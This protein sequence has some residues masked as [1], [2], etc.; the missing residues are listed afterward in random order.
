MSAP[1]PGTP[2]PETHAPRTPVLQR[3]EMEAWKA[4]EFE[5][6]RRLRE[7]GR[8]ERRRLYAEA[9]SAV[10]ALAVQKC[11][12]DS[13]EDRTAG[14]SPSLVEVLCQLVGRDDDVLEVGCG[15]GYT[16]LMLASHVRSMVGTEVSSSSVD[17]SS[18][19]MS[20]EGIANVRIAL[21]S[22]VELTDHFEPG[23]FSACLSIDV[24]E[25]LHPEDA[26][27]HLEQVFRLLRPGGRYIIV[28]PNR[29]NGPHDVTRTEFPEAKE[30]LGFHLN[31]STYAGT[32]R[33]CQAHRIH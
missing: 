9:Y 27:L 4:L 15:R 31:E 19:V 32:D 33:A 1:D 12:S 24:L 7:S 5:Y 30:P 26:A 6:G 3:G 25:H 11:R 17:E 20:R 14:T 23:A 2:R 8:E 16:C 18:R 28:T 22:G 29:L 10:S 13:P 21:V